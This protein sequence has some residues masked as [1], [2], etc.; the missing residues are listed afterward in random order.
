MQC[1]FL[2]VHMF[3][4]YVRMPV[5]VGICCCVVDIPS[6]GHVD[7]STGTSV[8]DVARYSCERG[9]TC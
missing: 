2:F 4:I 1:A 5:S 8:G 3:N 9:Y 6:N 7:T